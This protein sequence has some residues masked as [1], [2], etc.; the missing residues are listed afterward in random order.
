MTNAIV[1]NGVAKSFGSK[2]AVRDLDLVVP[3]GSL[4]G[5]IGPNGAGKTTTL[6]L[7]LSI[8]LPDR[9]TVGVLGRGSALEAKDLIGYLPEERGLYR[10]MKV[11]AFLAYIAR[12]KGLDGSTARRRSRSWLERLGLESV[13]KKR[14][15]ELSKG[16]QQKVGFAAAVLHGPELLVLDEPFSG[17]D[18]VSLRLVRELVFEL[19]ASGTTVVFSTHVM[20]Q[21]EE[22]CERVVMIHD[23]AK[24]LDAPVAEIRGGYD[25]RSI[26]LEPLDPRSDPERLRAIRGIASLTRTGAGFRIELTQDVDAVAVLGEIVLALPPA[27]VELKRKTHEDVFVENASGRGDDSR[28]ASL[29]ATLAVRDSGQ[30]GDA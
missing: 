27:R 3:K 15:E 13:E 4:C 11:G 20:A 21:A 25:P 22:L 16:M 17:L 24:V 8:L 10:K 14:C 2:Q 7:I 1:L 28:R 19:H 29:R 5:F 30:E 6:R 26:R 9:G 23:G 18:P 12:L